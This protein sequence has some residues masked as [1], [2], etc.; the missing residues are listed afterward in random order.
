MSDEPRCS[1]VKLGRDCATRPSQPGA[2]HGRRLFQ[3][4]CCEGF[5]LDDVDVCDVC[6]RCGWQDWYECHD[7]PDQEVRPNY[8]S[9]NRA[10]EILRRWGPSAACQANRA[11]GL[12]FERLERMSA[13]ELSA[14]KGMDE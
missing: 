9:L 12:S 11:R 1:P 6:T 8:L 7:S 4:M 14:L 2:E 3:C 5:T 13:E 10:R